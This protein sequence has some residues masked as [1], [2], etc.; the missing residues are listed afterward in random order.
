MNR[1]LIDAIARLRH[2]AQTRHRS[3]PVPLSRTVKPLLIYLEDHG[4]ISSYRASADGRTAWVSFR[5][6]STPSQSLASLKALAIPSR[7]RFYSHRHLARVWGSAAHVILSTSRGL[8]HHK[9]LLG[10][11]NRLP[12]GGIGVAIVRP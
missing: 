9:V 12:L 11:R 10:Q 8:A 3:I 6:N 7:P 1:T 2:G 4:L 5:A